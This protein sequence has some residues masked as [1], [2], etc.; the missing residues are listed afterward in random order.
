MKHTKIT[1]VFGT[2]PE[3]IKMCPLILEL[4]RRSVGIRVVTSGQHRELCRE[5]TEYFGILPDVDLDIMSHG[6]TLLEITEKILKKMTDEL[7]KNTPDVLLVHGD[8]ATAFA[9][10]LA[11]FYLG[12]KVGHVEAGLRSGDLFSPYPEEFYRRSI[13]AMSFFH[14]CPTV[15]SKNNLISERMPPARIYVTGN[16]V[17]DALGY[18]IDRFNCKP[19]ESGI[20][21]LMTLHRRENRGDG[22]L[23]VLR[24]VK[25]AAGKYPDLQ[26]VFPV[27][28]AKEVREAADMLSGVSGIRL[29]DPLPL[30]EFHKLLFECDIILSDSGGVTEEA[31]SLAK[32]LLLA[33]DTTERPEAFSYDG[34]RL[35]GTDENRIF[36][37]L[38]ELIESPKT[39]NRSKSI[40]SP[41][42]DGHAS[43]RIS[44]ILLSFFS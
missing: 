27:H 15:M 12:I 39:K 2:R 11:A 25:R 17:V 37:A 33:R 14:F 22:M 28:P 8:T 35:V 16:T 31:V 5:V 41:F 44:D 21:L 30:P 23:S 18:T 6:Q 7:S 4:K 24:A 43:E 13:D 1:C 9:S 10:A 3:A 32:P 36:S 42:G 26:I 38:C 19:D 29:I 40:K 20:L 34:I